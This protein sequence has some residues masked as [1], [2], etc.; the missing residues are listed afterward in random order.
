MSSEDKSVEMQVDP[1]DDPVDDPV[2]DPLTSQ[3]NSINLLIETIT[4]SSKTLST[5]MK[6]FTKDVNKLKNSKTKK[7]KKIVD[8]DVPR[9]L[10]ALEK[11]VEISE[12]LSTFLGL[13]PG[14]HQSRQF[15]T[16]SINKYIK[17]HDIQNPENRRYILLDSKDEGRAL[18]KLL[19]DPD[20]PLTFFNIQ[21]YLKVHYPKTENDAKEKTVIDVSKKTESAPTTDS[22]P[23]TESPPVKKKIVRRV[24][25]KSE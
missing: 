10:S 23:K 11:P 18:G 6:Q 17:L 24:V 12:E 13:T 22:P 5:E 25:K 19:R 15:I 3:L 20:Q 4:K 7:V 9:K 1:V 21:R 8:P 16:Q 2:V 14:E